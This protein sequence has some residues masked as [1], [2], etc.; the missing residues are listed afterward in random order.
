MINL[1]E[2]ESQKPDA[3]K[4]EA[5]DP[6]GIRAMFKEM[7]IHTLSSQMSKVETKLEEAK[8]DVRI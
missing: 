2:D 5:P 3:P 6:I 4:E 1:L 8:D 7:N